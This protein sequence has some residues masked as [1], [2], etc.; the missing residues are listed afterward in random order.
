MAAPVELALKY[1]Q[2]L[3]D[4]AAIRSECVEI[5]SFFHGLLWA[6]STI[7]SAARSE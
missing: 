3:R 5:F 6:V 7:F 1:T 4:A 2:V